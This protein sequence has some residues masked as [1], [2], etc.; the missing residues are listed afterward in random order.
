[1]LA[2]FKVALKVMLVSPTFAKEVAAERR[3]GHQSSEVLVNFKFT[4]AAN[5]LQL[6][7]VMHAMPCACQNKQAA[8]API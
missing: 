4:T 7:T 6:P 2:S 1:M 3:A 8:A 5:P